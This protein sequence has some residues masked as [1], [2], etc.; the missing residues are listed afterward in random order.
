MKQWHPVPAEYAAALVKRTWSKDNQAPEAVAYLWTWS[1]MR[2]SVTVS[3]RDLARYAGWSNWKAR[4]MLQR[5]RTEY[6]DWEAEPHRSV[7]QPYSDRTPA[8]HQPY[9][10]P[11]QKQ[12]LIRV[13]QT[14][15]VQ[16]PDTNRTPTERSRVIPNTNTNT[17][18]STKHTKP[19]GSDGVNVAK[20]WDEIQTKRKAVVPGAK[21]MTLTKPRRKVLKARLVEHCEQDVLSVVDWWLNSTHKRAVYLRQEGHGIDTLLRPSNFPQYL[22]FSKEAKSPTRRKP[23]PDPKAPPKRPQLPTLADYSSEEIRKA[24]TELIALRDGMKPATWKNAIL[25][26]L[27]Q[28]R[29]KQTVAKS[30]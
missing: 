6:N 1:V 21:Q 12:G 25:T 17:T 9:T 28:E 11:Q 5:V 15:T 19:L 22:D 10:K 20:V 8:E 13:N 2:N 4:Q 30:E 3:I 26:Y 16:E 27:H 29:Q 7:Q 18:T 14:P 24:Q 23:K